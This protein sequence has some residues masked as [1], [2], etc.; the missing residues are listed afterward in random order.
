MT[1]SVTRREL[2][3]SP[4]ISCAGSGSL[5]RR[6]EKTCADCK[7]KGWVECASQQEEICSHCKGNGKVP[8][9]VKSSCGPCE[10]KGYLIGIIEITTSMLP[11][12][13]CDGSGHTEGEYSNCPTCEGLGV[14]DDDSPGTKTC[15]VCEGEGEVN[16]L[17]CDQ[18]GGIGTL[19]VAH[20]AV[21]E[22]ESPCPTCHGEGSVPQK[23][24]CKKCHGSG[25]VKQ[26]EE[27]DV[28]PKPMEKA[29]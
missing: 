15:P 2:R 26:A 8:C 12:S 5:S 7:G 1:S 3:K 21:S 27:K 28:T 10:G 25:A 6:A 18:C 19:D 29:V 22:E 20:L 24:K 23:L 14:V 13:A 4:C 11:C 16:N 17:C 9:V